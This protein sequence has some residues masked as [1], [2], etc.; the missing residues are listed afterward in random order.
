MARSKRTTTKTNIAEGKRWE[1]HVGKVA[2]ACRQFPDA[3]FDAFLSDPPYGISFMGKGWDYDVPQPDEWREVL[4]VMKPGAPGIAFSGARTYHRTAV[5]VEDGGFEITDMFSWL[6]GQGWPKGID[7]AK[8]IDRQRHDRPETLEV[9]SW[10]REARD[11]A[12]VSNADID[13]A[14]GLHGM[15]GHWTS[16][17]S[18]TSQPQ[19]PTLEYVPLLLQV[20]RVNEADVPERIR[21]LLVVLNGRKGEPGDAWKN[22]EIV[23]YR[24]GKDGRRVPKKASQADGEA[25]H[26]ITFADRAPNSPEAAEWVGYNSQLKPG[27][28]PA[29]LCFRPREGTFA[30]NA[31]KH[32]VGGLNI[33]ES[34][35]GVV[36]G[37]RWKQ[38]IGERE[39][40][41]IYGKLTRGTVD[42]SIVEGRYPTNVLL[43]HLPGCRMVGTRPSGETAS[44]TRSTGEVVSQNR[45]ATGPNYGREKLGEVERPDVEVWE[46]V[47]GCVVPRIDGQSGNCPGSLA[48]RADP[49]KA[50]YQKA[51]DRRSNIYNRR[52]SSPSNVYADDG[53]ASRFFHQTQ[54]TGDEL[55]LLEEAAERFVYAAKAS[56]LERGSRNDHPTVKPIALMKYLAGLL[57]PPRPTRILVP[58]SGSGSEMLGCL[59]AGWPEVVGIELDPRMADVARWRIANATVART[60]LVIGG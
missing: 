28:E 56:E 59:L 44:I 17:T 21:E 46:C 34:R 36:G 2:E 14:F 23:G 38:L 41:T 16:Q 24:P 19:V 50:H 29:V 57:R 12:R 52:Q 25:H 11:R 45:A 51:Y 32:G 55:A 33:G 5:G 37:S 26:A 35:V 53:G 40:A 20:L 3:Y 13:A 8:A 43:S 7:L 22:A 30:D 60:E 4:R 49:T 27:C 10:I 39:R 48:G 15:A 1:V 42:D 47:D 6:Y 58:F 9:T 54:L 31:L 18:Q